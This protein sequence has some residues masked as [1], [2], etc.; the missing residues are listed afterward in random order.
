MNKKRVWR[1]TNTYGIYVIS[2]VVATVI[3][4]ALLSLSA[5]GAVSEELTIEV[6]AD[7]GTCEIVAEDEVVT[8]SPPPPPPPSE[9]TDLGSFYNPTW[10]L[11]QQRIPAGE[12]VS[13]SFTAD[14][15]GQRGI[16]E[17][18]NNMPNLAASGYVFKAWF[19]E[20][21]A[22][23]ALY[24]DPYCRRY[25]SDPNPLQMKW[26]QASVETRWSC[27]L[28]YGIRTLY[29]N[30]EVGCFEGIG[31]GRCEMGSDY[32]RDYFVRAYPQ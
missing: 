6:D 16:I 24:N 21:P 2:M 22:G 27:N 4:Y 7:A 30:M 5:S 26:N 15:V 18:T 9:V 32:F 17:F 13:F 25:S 29:F 20:E 28:G 11:Y 14:A 12:V 31:N 3:I 8:V 23:E 10:G 19:S 1:R